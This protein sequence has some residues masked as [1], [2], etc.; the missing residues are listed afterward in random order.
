MM[1][2]SRLEASGCSTALHYELY[3]DGWNIAY[4][5]PSTEHG[6]MIREGNGLMNIVKTIHFLVGNKRTLEFT[7]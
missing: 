6:Y 3:K 1:A 2:L 4:G 5:R 7:G